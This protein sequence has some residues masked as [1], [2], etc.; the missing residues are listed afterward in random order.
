MKNIEITFLKNMKA[1]MRDA[2]ALYNA[3]R[4]YRPSQQNAVV[5]DYSKE[6][7][8]VLFSVRRGT[9]HQWVYPPRAISGHDV[10]AL[11]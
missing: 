3:S 4:R 7:L 9:V 8:P 11:D 6:T 1:S 10:A 5:L 2:D